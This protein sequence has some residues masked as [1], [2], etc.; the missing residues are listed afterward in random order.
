MNKRTSGIF[1]KDN[2]GHIIVLHRGRLNKITKQFVRSHFKPDQW[3]YFKDGDGTQNKAILVGDLS[4]DNFISSLKTFI[5]EA[6]RIK[7]LSR[8]SKIN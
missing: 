6:E 3:A 2:E 7:N 1:A 5:L 8:D 4:S